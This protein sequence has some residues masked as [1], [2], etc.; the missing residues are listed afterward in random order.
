MHE[1]KFHQLGCVD[2]SSF[3]LAIGP[4]LVFSDLNKIEQFVDNISNAS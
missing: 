3:E 1:D 4:S 2:T